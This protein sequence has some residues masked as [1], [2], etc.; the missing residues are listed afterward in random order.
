M[1]SF[2]LGEMLTGLPFVV[3]WPLWWTLFAGILKY[4]SGAILG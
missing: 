3:A 4:I 1:L 2:F